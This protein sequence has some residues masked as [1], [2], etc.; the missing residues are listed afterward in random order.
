MKKG[1]GQSNGPVE[2][3]LIHI[4]NFI[5]VSKTTYLNVKECILKLSIPYFEIKLRREYQRTKSKAI[6]LC[7]YTSPCAVA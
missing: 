2:D 1:F 5:R 3:V 7:A 6:M 4:F